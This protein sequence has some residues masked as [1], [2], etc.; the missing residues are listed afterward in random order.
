MN[1]DALYDALLDALYATFG[2]HQGFRVTHAKGMLVEGSFTATPDAAGISRA[3]HFQGQTLPV[4]VRFSNF[5]GI[6]GTRDG[7]PSASPRGLAIRF[8]M[9]KGLYTDIV[10]HSFDGFPVATPE[11][12]LTFLQ[13]IAASAAIP[14]NPQP[15][16]DFLST[17]PRAKHFLDTPKPGPESYVGIEYFGVNALSFSDAHNHSVMGRYRIEPFQKTQALNDSQA[18]AMPDNYL[19]DE[20]TQRLKNSPVRMRLL[21]QLATPGDPVDDGSVSWSRLNPEI[22]LGVITLRS[23]IPQDMQSLEQQRA[24]FNPGHLIDG[25]EPGPDPMIQARQK[26]YEKALQRRHRTGQP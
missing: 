6:P 18:Q 14:G 10:A 20:L 3:A 26:I 22:E 2:Q 13:G 7:D 8:F 5:S 17:H 4:T 11:E 15:L 24:D 12:F 25:I 9:A 21:L 16:N 19:R 23:I 1:Q